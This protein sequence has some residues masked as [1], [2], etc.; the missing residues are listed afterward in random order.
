MAAERKGLFISFEGIDGC[1][2]ST[3]I[4]LLKEYWD[5][6]GREYV[7]WR[8]PG[9][10]MLGE[11]VRSC[12]LDVNLEIAAPAELLLFLAARA[13]LVKLVAA[14]RQGCREPL[15]LLPKASWSVL[16]ARNKTPATTPAQFADNLRDA[17][18]KA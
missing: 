6:A 14:M 17:A 13:Q 9:A 16:K 18:V 3:Q 4:N 10:T 12:L 7:S 8:E 1:G 15:P 5:S 2:K 11:R